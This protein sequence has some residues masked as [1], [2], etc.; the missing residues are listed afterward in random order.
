MI[1]SCGYRS[2]LHGRRPEAVGC[3]SQQD[4]ASALAERIQEWIADGVAPAEIGVSARFNLTLDKAADHLRMAGIPVTRV[5]GSIPPGSEGV[6]LATMHAM[7]GLEFRAVA[8]LGV[9][10]GVM[11]F[12]REITPAEVDWLQHE[13]D[14]LRERCLLFVACTRAREVL[15]V[16]W[17]GKAS[18]FIPVA[19][20]A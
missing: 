12:A 3:A 6:R 4:E 18:E 7:K 13:G 1:H 9:S 17:S 16:S 10:A 11:P 20:G 19:V 8:V 14:I 2:L 5:K 15:R